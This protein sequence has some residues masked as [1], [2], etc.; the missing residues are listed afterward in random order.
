MG[1]R[2]RIQI[3][4]L[5]VLVD[6]GLLVAA[7]M[8]IAL[9]AAG[10]QARLQAATGNR[11]WSDHLRVTSQVILPGVT[12]LGINL[13]E[14]NYYDSG[15]MMR[16]LSTAIP[17]SRAWLTEA[18]CTAFRAARRIAQT[19]VTR[20]RG[21]PAFGTNASYESWMG[22]PSAQGQRQGERAEWGWIRM[23]LDGAG[24]AV[25]TG[26]WLA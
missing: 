4:T 17:G 2:G 5:A 16:N 6:A 13:G 23:T 26:D 19:R 9:V 12:R 14:Q 7:L 15:Q 3:V 22:Q 25:G 20:S 1:S 10:S 24:T 8:L 21:R 11:G 18:F